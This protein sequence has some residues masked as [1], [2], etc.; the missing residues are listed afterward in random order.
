MSS[1]TT[2]AETTTARESTHDDA[3][4][5]PVF[6]LARLGRVAARRLNDYLAVTGLKRPHAV[7][8]MELR[9]F[10]PMSQQ[11]LG[12]R[13]HIDP[14]N[15]VAFLNTLEDDGLLV[16]RRDRADRRRHIVEITQEG[17]GRV[18][19]CD[20]PLD[21]LEDQLFVGLSTTDRERLRQLLERVL[22]TMSIEEPPPAE[23]GEID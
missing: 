14:S 11:S 17:I 12:E 8:L 7:I 15:L 20:E 10:G 9:N 22:V 23:N 18:P 6:M 13:L 21:A 1:T 16:R 4:L 19:V 3:R 2:P 5:R